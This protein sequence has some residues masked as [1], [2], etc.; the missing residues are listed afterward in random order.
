MSAPDGP[1]KPRLPEFLAEN[2]EPGKA[3]III[4]ED[5]MRVIIELV[6]RVEGVESTTFEMFSKPF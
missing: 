2:W 3:E 4:E 5:T 1:D 6:P